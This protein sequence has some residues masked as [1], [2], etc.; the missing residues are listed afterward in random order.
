MFRVTLMATVLTCELL[1][2]PSLAREAT[3]STLR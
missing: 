2:G 1:L 3:Q